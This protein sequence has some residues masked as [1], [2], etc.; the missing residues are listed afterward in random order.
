MTEIAT[1]APA[2][3]PE[4]AMPTAFQRVEDNEKFLRSKGWKWVGCN[5]N[6]LSF[7]ED[8]LAQ[9][10]KSKEVKPAVTLPVPGGGTEVVMQTHVPPCN[11]RHSTVDAVRIQRSRDAAGINTLD[12]QIEL[13]EKELQEL[14]DRKEVERQAAARPKK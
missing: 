5:D 10:P 13:R 14:Y 3:R 12:A 8:P 1:T 7:W 4:A 2:T 11:W 9:D 6:G